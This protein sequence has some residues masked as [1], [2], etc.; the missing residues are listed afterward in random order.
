MGGAAAVA[1]AFEL[2][3]YQRHRKKRREAKERALKLLM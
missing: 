2:A 3:A 1:L